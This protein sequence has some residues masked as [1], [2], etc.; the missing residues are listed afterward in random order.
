DYDYDNEF[1]YGL[2][3]ILDALEPALAG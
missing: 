1:A 2:E 3:L